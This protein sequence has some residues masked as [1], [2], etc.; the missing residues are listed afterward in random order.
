MSNMD[1]KLG[2]QL[3]E[4]SDEMLF[5]NVDLSDQ[6]KQKIRHQTAAEKKGRRFGF[7]KRWMN[8]IAAMAAALLIVAGFL[9]FQEPSKKAPAQN[10][11]GNV[12]TPTTNEGTSGSELSQLVT[13]KLSTVE[14]AEKAFGEGLLVPSELPEG[15]TLKEISAVGMKGEPA[16]DILFN[17]VSGDKTIMYTV[18]R[19]QAVFPTDLFTTVKISKNDGLIFEQAELTELYWMI[20]NVQYSIV[21]NLTG[22]EARKAAESV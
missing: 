1:H 21:G 8:G 5:A 9:V 19:M 15:F 3:R 17:Y 6:L 12:D 7:S 11:I 22:D 13:S 14:E 16:R 20:D 2:Q 10:P 18:S 4:E